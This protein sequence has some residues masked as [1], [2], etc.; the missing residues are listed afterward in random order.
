M[1]QKPTTRGAGG[2]N[3]KLRFVSYY[4]VSTEKQGSSGLGL[5]AQREAVSRH[6][7]AAG[8]VLIAEFTEVETGTNKRHRPEMTQ[9]LGMCRLRRAMLV[10]AKLD[11]LA[12]NVHFISGLM[13]SKVEFVACDNPHATKVLVHIMAAF[14]EYEAEAISARTREALAVVKAEIDAGRGW[15]SKRSGRKLEK[16]GNPNLRCGDRFG[17]ARAARMARTAKANEH[18]S[19]VLPLIKAAQKAGCQ[20]LGELARA[21]TARGIETATGGLNWNS[22]QVRR[23]LARSAD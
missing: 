1:P 22:T 11:R 9:A 19:D 5:E 10:I 6:V 16:L 17:D 14:A 23:I 21:L 15:V 13:E 8:G 12:R 2:V 7:A 3:E 20:S 18:A 4:R